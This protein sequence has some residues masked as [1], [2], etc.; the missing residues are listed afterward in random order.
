ME[1]L[2]RQE[3]TDGGMVIL[4]AN[5]DDMNPEFTSYITDLLL[6]AGANDVYWIPIIMKKGRPGIMLNVLV[7]EEG[8]AAMEQVIFAETTTLGLRYVRA[9]CHRLGREFVRVETRFGPMSVKVGY[10]G[11]KP[12]QFAPEFRECEEAARRF[13]VPLKEVYEEVRS[14]YRE[15]AGPLV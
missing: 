8:I 3:H 15:L 14:R 6:A 7:G 4:Q 2:H 13:G 1:H 11:G 9:E 12:V 10:H 5:L